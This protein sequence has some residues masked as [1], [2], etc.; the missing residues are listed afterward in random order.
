[1]IT[2]FDRIARSL[3]QGIQFI[4]SLDDRG[5]IDNSPT[6]KFIRNIM[7]SFLEF[8]RDMIIQCTQEGKGS[9]SAK[10]EFSDDRPKK[11]SRV[12]I[13]SALELL[14]THSYKHVAAMTYISKATLGK[15][16]AKQKK[17]RL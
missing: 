3:I 4:E 5:T 6:E 11:F 8:E 13:S 2:K 1:M 9:C 7:L 17:F 15:A 16:K 10:Y 14:Q 12:P